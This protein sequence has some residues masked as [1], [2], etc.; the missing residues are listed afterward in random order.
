MSG[1]LTDPYKVL[2]VVAGESEPTAGEPLRYLYEQRPGTRAKQSIYAQ[3]KRHL[4]GDVVDLSYRYFWDDWGIRS[5]TVDVHYRWNWSGN[6]AFQPH[7]RYY[8]QSA[9]D[10]YRHSLVEGEPLAEFA[11][12][13]YRLGE[14]QA[15]T[16]GLKYEQALG[17]GRIS[18]RI[19]Y[20]L[21]GGDGSPA[22]AVGVL[23]GQD[24]FPS[25][26]AAIVQFGYSRS[27]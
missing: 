5:H 23:Q 27:W 21:Q 8:H 16:A 6:R 24:L 10:F 11:S 15:V 9:A 4:A 3:G 14:F 20:Y 18:A 22:D 2:S 12:G 26:G 1:Y 13:D 7:L 17:V 25:V 19:E